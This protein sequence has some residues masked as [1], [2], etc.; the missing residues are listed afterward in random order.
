MIRTGLICIVLLLSCFYTQGQDVS[1][2]IGKKQIALNEYFTITVQV[3]NDRLK[4]YSGFPDIT[5]FVKR[6]TSSSTS[7]NYVNGRMSSTQS[8]TQNYQAT[9]KGTFAVKPFT[10]MINAKEV[11]LEGFKIEVG[12]PMQRQARRNPFDSF[13]GGTSQPTEFINVEADAFLA[14]TSDKNEIYVGEGL[15][16]TLAFYVAESNRA[17][18]RFHDLA[19]QITEIVK[20]MKPANCWEENFTIDQI[21]G[22]PIM[23]NNKK[24]TRYK[25]YQSTLYPLNVEDITFPTVG[26][27]MVK[28]RVA[29]NPSFFGRNRQEDF[30][31]FYSKPKKIQVVDLPPHPLKNLVAVGSFR[32]KEQLDPK[33]KLSTGE[34]FNY[35]FIIQGEGNI[36]SVEP[37]QP[38]DDK[39]FDF[40]DPNVLQNVNR[41]N[42]RVSGSKTF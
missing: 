9:S 35:K 41:A 8:I 39:N 30:E 24:Y 14:L 1:V 19:N 20:V 37:P 6:G 25:I 40:Y 5:G 16:A 7:T 17:E 12:E 13:F 10:I 29:K 31:T 11:K 33:T 3:Q 23:I 26:L 4:K 27:E 15:T 34:S 18:M 22:S 32:L 28:Y 2:R 42:G 21:V 38:T 36:S